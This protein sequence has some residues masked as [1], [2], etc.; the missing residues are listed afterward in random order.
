[1][2]SKYIKICEKCENILHSVITGTSIT[3]KCQA[4]QM[5]Y[6]S[7]EEDSMLMEVHTGFMV[8]AKKKGELIYYNDSNPKEVI[9][10]T[11][12]DVKIVRYERE[13]TGHKKYGCKCG[14]TWTI[15]QTY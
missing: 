5:V 10:C 9:D 1:M 15:N 11:K 6:P 8:M 14:N 7:T 13:S 4:C 2:S 12:C 3:F